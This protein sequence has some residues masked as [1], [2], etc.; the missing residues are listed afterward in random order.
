MLEPWKPAFRTT[1]LAVGLVTFFRYFVISSGAFLWA[2]YAQQEIGMSV[3]TSDSSR[4]GSAVR[5]STPNGFGVSAR[6][7]RISS[8]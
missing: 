1:V 5:R 4:S 6:A 2:Y 7:A 8:T 3:A